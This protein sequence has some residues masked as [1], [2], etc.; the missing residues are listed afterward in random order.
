[1]VRPM[2]NSLTLNLTATAL[3][4]D[5]EDVRRSKQHRQT[6]DEPNEGLDDRHIREFAEFGVEIVG[7]FT[8]LAS[9]EVENYAQPGKQRQTVQDAEVEVEEAGESPAAWAPISQGISRF[10][11][12]SAN[13]SGAT[14]AVM[15]STRPM[16]AILDPIAFADRD[17]ADIPSSSIRYRPMISGADVPTAMGGQADYDLRHPRDSSRLRRRH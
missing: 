15:P 4:G 5:D 1:M 2:T 12:S 13:G 9:Q 6:D 17:L 3:R 7:P 8:V 14:I 16:L 11:V 10:R